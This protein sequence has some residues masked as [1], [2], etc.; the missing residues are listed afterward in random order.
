MLPNKNQF[1]NEDPLANLED[2][3]ALN[4]I[5]SALLLTLGNLAGIVTFM[6]AVSHS[7]LLLSSVSDDTRMLSVA[8]HNLGIQ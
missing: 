6:Y 7:L 8:T 5:G 4:T 1:N 3:E 2:L